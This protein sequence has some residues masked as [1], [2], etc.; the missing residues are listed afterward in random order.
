MLDDLESKIYL[1]KPNS[2]EIL[3]NTSF[4]DNNVISFEI[5]LE[6]YLGDNRKV[7]ALNSGTAAIHLA[8]ILAGV[9]KD[10]FVICQ[11]FTFV[12]TANPILYQNAKPVFIDSEI[13]TW[14]ICPLLLEEAIKNC[15]LLK[16]KP[17]AIIVNC[18]Y[19]MP[20]KIEEIISIAKFY[21]IKLIEDAASGLG[22]SYKKQK[23]G[24]FGDFGII[25]F[26]ENKILTT[27]GGGA[28]ICKCEEDKIRA[29]YLASQA[30]EKYDYYQHSEIGYNYRMDK[31]SAS[32]GLSEL[33][34]IE[35]Y[36]LSR[37]KINLFY[38]ELF[39]NVEGIS[40]FHNS[41]DNYFSNYW[42]T[43]ILINAK[44]TGF[45]KEEMRGQLLKDKIESRPLWKPMHLQPV[46]KD[47]S[48]Y[49]EGIS[50]RLFNSGICLPS[51]ANVTEN[52]LER[53]ATSIK[54]F[55]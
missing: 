13:D 23:C 12:A 37:R 5:A 33:K 46:F 26:N 34:N 4:K 16:K 11:S 6:K 47:Y 48:Y 52:D 2:K 24:T 18:N 10:D 50:E 54:K 42:L 49:G 35:E 30:K 28:L 43:C 8:L 29:I 55:L 51:G 41:D 39:H 21:D 45:S 1:S 40:V 19:G 7:V 15:I 9:Q 20:P 25:S 22:A 53:I 17:K 38:V 32:V 31:L 3:I 44:L 36:I 14:S 27:F